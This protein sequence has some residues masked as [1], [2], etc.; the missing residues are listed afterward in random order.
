MFQGVRRRD[1]AVVESGGEE[2]RS[3]KHRRK[4]EQAVFDDRAQ[5]FSEDDEMKS[6]RLRFCQ[7]DQHTMLRLWLVRDEDTS[8]TL[9]QLRV[10]MLFDPG[11]NSAVR[12]TR[13]ELSKKRSHRCML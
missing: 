8:F 9:A 13:C 5:D 12:R 10:A 7:T 11:G 3:K 1:V 2:L 4:S 6:L